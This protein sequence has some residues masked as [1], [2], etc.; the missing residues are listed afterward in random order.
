MRHLLR[1]CAGLAILFASHA[2]QAGAEPDKTVKFDVYPRNFTVDISGPYPGGKAPLSV[3]D[4]AVHFP[5]AALT[6]TVAA[7]DL[8]IKAPGRQPYAA[9]V[10]RADLMKSIWPSTQLILTPDNAI[11]SLQDTLHFHGLA[12]AGGGAVLAAGLAMAFAGMKRS[13]QGL[14]DASKTNTRLAAEVRDK[15]YAEQEQQRQLL[16]LQRWQNERG[17]DESSGGGALFGPYKALRHLGQGG[18]ASVYKVVRS[19]DWGK[20]DAAIFALKTIREKLD[21]DHG[22]QQ[23]FRRESEELRR[24]EHPG[25]ARY[26]DSG[27]DAQGRPYLAMEFLSGG[28]LENVT[29]WSLERVLRVGIDVGKALAY[30]HSRN[31]VHR[32][33]K[34]ENIMLSPSGEVKL[35]DFGLAVDRRNDANLTKTGEIVGTQEYLAMWSIMDSAQR[36]EEGKQDQ[37]ALGVT[38]FKLLTG[39]TPYQGENPQKTA[40]NVAMG[41]ATPLRHYLPT[42]SPELEAILARMTNADKDKLYPNIQEAVQALQ[43]VLDHETGRRAV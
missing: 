27:E 1:V 22:I 3:T 31:V 42:A 10:K 15:Q 11:V 33:I 12:L 25:V 13:K 21:S 32:D 19:A 6:S 23:R 2:D 7:V 29:D 16:I 17:F 30:L 43:N 4:G 38:L 5:A 18:M 41:R 39:Y 14:H 20:P 9:T 24:C 35:A 40:S 37:Y 8:E 28:S 36:A 26:V 34:P